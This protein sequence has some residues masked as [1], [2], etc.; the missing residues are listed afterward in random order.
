[1]SCSTLSCHNRRDQ[2]QAGDQP[3]SLV[4]AHTQ[5]AADGRE[6]CGDQGRVD[7]VEDR[8]DQQWKVR[9]TGIGRGGPAGPAVT[10]RFE[11]QPCGGLDDR[12]APDPTSPEVGR[13]SGRVSVIRKLTSLGSSWRFFSL[14]G[15]PSE[16]TSGKELTGWWCEHLRKRFSHFSQV[17][18]QARRSGDQD[19]E[20]H[21]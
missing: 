10:I 12:A 13:G 19:R 9:T 18:R 2:V 15:C 7:R 4:A 16:S 3:S 5:A 11:R 1:M 21:R 6:G 17:N 20:G 8:A 14:G